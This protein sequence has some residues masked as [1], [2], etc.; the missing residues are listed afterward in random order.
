MAFFEALSCVYGSSDKKDLIKKA[1]QF[2]KKELFPRH[3][4][5]KVIVSVIK[6]LEEKEG[7]Y[8]DCY[9]DGDRIYRIRLDSELEKS[10]EDEFFSTLLHEMVHVKQYCKRE[11]TQPRGK[12][13][14]TRFKGEDYSVT[15]AYRSQPWEKEA[16]KLEKV[17]LKKFKKEILNAR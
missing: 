8:G 15:M 14:I 2:A 7:I 16:R 11:L 6:R 17:L 12:F 5:V 10:N 1:I 9:D 3:Q 13:W 4:N